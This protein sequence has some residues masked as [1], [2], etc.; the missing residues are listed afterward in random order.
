M[1][2]G[3]GLITSYDNTTPQKVQITDRIIL[4][5]PY[6]ITTITSLGLNNESKF[7]FVNMPGR[8][9][10]WLEDAYPAVSGK[11]NDSDL[12][13]STSTVSLTVTSQEVANL[14]HIGDVIYVD[15]EPMQ[16]TSIVT[17]AITVTRNYGTFLASSL[18]HDT[19][20][21]FYIRYNARVEGADSTASPWTE[22]SSGTNYSTILHKEVNISR[23]DQLFPNYGVADLLKYRITQNM[24][25]LMEQLDKLPYYGV[26]YAG[27]SA[28][29]RST[30]G[31][32]TFI[33]TNA[34]AMS[35][36]ALT[37]AAIDAEFIQIHA[38]GGKTDLILCDAWG[39]KK[40]NDFYEGFVSTGRDESIG[41]ILIKTLMHP[42][43][44]SLVKVVVD[45]H[46]P[47][48]SMYILDT[49]YV[50]YLTIDPFFYETLA[51]HGDSEKGE[52]IGEYGFVAAANKFHS[53]LSGY[54]VTA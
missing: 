43:T 48:G 19:S 37:R 36:G 52:T 31:F 4:A 44:G 20:S 15:T 40:I 6:D 45:R 54:S 47:S 23:D 26:R 38:A 49:R 33:T 8:S 50:G 25:I 9:Y 35:S 21:T 10:A 41:G 11:F 1:T 2:T 18:S 16:V 28:L 53:I 42:I 5:D 34:T 12:S 3:S 13:S 14:L 24:D 46:C 29:G 51:K 17:T 27:T 32:S 22:V 30:G 7:Q 39:Q